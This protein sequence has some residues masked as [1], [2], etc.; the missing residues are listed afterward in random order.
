[1]FL[2]AI[3]DSSVVNSLFRAVSH[4]LLDIFFIYISNIF[5]FLG[6]SPL[7]KCSIPSPLSLHLWGCSPT[8][9]TTPFF[10]LWH[11]LTQGQWTAS[12]PKTSH[13]SLPHMWPATW[14]PPCVFFAWWSTSRELWGWGWWSLAC[15]HCY[16]IHGAAKPPQLL[17]CLLQLLHHGTPNSVQWLAVSIYPTSVSV[18]LWHSLSGDSHFKL[19][20]ANTSQHPSCLG[21]KLLFQVVGRA[22]DKTQYFVHAHQALCKLSCTL[23]LNKHSLQMQAFDCSPVFILFYFYYSFYAFTFQITSPS[24]L[25]LHKLHLP[26]LPTLLWLDECASILPV[27]QVCTWCL[28]SP[29]DGHVMGINPCCL[30]KQPTQCS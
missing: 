13:P 22:E 19:T 25:P 17:Q 7:L 2:R 14:V 18:R 21:C 24:L 10:L 26:I 9:L 30:R 27:T 23:L 16:S 1:M 15:W 12:G 28:C 20:S 5:P 8:H 29:E 11:F 6:L 3:W 4:F